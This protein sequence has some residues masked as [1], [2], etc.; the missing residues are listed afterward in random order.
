MANAVGR[1][2]RFGRRHGHP[3][4]IEMVDENMA[5]ATR[6]HAVESG[7]TSEGHTLI[8]L[9]GGGPIHGSCIAEKIGIPR[10]LVP[11]GAGV[12]SAIG[13]LRAPVGYEVVRNLYQR[14]GNAIEQ[15]LTL[16]LA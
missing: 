6:I 8:A 12:S 14:V 9:G 16:P 13:F 11:S 5:N 7:K 2:A 3:R 15:K 4:V 10:V 1:S